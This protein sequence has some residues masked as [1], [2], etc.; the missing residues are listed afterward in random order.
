MCCE[1]CIIYLPR[2]HKRVLLNKRMALDIR[3]ESDIRFVKASLC[4][5]PS[6]SERVSGWNHQITY[7]QSGLE[8][9]ISKANIILYISKNLHFCPCF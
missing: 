1:E 7:I 6:P 5:M 8:F 4:V 9:Y 2:V 3:E